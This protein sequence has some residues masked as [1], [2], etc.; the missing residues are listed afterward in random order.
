[1]SEI[2]GGMG[3]FNNKALS[4]WIMLILK[5]PGSSGENSSEHTAR[6]SLRDFMRSLAET[7]Q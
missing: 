4:H 1:M 3:C 7:A 6:R 5:D 2:V